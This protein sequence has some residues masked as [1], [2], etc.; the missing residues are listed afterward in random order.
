[1]DYL[2]SFINTLKTTKNLSNKT[3]Q[4]YS[5]DIKSFINQFSNLTIEDI[6][7]NDIF[8]YITFLQ[9]SKQLKD[10]SIKRHIVSLKIFFEFLFNNQFITKNIFLGQKF[11]F[12]HEI[13]LPKTV[14]LVDVKK[15]LNSLSLLKEIA[16]SPFA[17]FEST[18]N[19]AIIDLLV[20]TGI[21]IGE[22]VNIRLKDIIMNEHTILIIGKGRKQR[23]LYISCQESWNNL[24]DWL[25]LRTQFTTHN[26]Y[27]F[28]N[29]YLNQLSI[30]AVDA[31]F[32]KHCLLCNIAK[33]ATPHYL[34]HT[35]ATNLLSNG[36]DLRSVQELLGHSSIATTEIY[37]HVTMKRKIQ[38]LNEFN[39]RNK[40]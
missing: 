3:I 14:T 22:C 1:M 6:A 4:A 37:T 21:R 15:L 28:L 19:L 2:M 17:L 20:T 31:L 25:K 9:S 39:Y 11:N 24:K 12:R 30:H 35:F 10:S 8:N 29:R 40:L 27:L 33:E 26:D 18:R 16:P 5:L 36:A 34:R 38:V 23:L 32:K 13:Q 7:I